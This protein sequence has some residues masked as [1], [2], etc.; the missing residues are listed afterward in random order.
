MISRL[1]CALGWH[2]WEWT[3]GRR[4]YYGEKDVCRYCGR[5]R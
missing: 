5:E 4:W 3:T 1:L 2:R